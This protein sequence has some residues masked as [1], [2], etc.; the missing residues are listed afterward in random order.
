MKEKLS[1]LVKNQKYYIEAKEKI[2][3]DWMAYDSPKKILQ[4]HGI[5]PQTFIDNYANG[6]FDYFMGVISGELDI[7]NCPTMQ[8]LLLYLKDRDVGADELFEIC[9]NFRRS[10]VE[11]TYESGL[12]SKNLFE[13]LYY[14]FDKNFNGV[15]KSYTD[16]IFQKEQEINR[17][18]KLLSEYKKALDESALISKTDLNGN[19][20]YVNKKLI[21][22]CGYSEADLR[23]TGLGK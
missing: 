7:G 15:L 4:L 8:D 20:T 2:L 16:T 18:V 23:A 6:V 17:N 1:N 22:L 14:L 21:D 3:L 5:K 10:M 12:N 13:E 19:I 11:F 9:S